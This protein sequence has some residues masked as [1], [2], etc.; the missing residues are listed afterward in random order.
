MVVVTVPDEPL[1]RRALRRSAVAPSAVFVDP[2]GRRARRTRRAVVTLVMGVTGAIGA[3]AL[4]V[5]TTPDLQTPALPSAAV[6]APAA[7]SPLPVAPRTPVVAAQEPSATEPQVETAADPQPS[8]VTDPAVVS[9]GTTNP[10]PSVAAPVSSTT[11]GNSA[12][13]PGHT[14]VHPT[15]PPRP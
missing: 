13:A 12:S 1:T 15:A 14:S 2:S 7:S 4:A 9:V 5:T 6:R 10:A 3:V 8:S 11:R